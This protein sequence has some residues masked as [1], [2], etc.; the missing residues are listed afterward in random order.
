MYSKVRQGAAAIADFE[1]LAL[2]A[3]LSRDVSV[4]RVVGPMA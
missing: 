4:W 3:E 1:C 2:V